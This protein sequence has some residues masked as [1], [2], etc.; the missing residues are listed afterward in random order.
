MGLNGP[1]LIRLSFKHGIWVGD[2][3]VGGTPP[4]KIVLASVV[5][6]SLSFSGNE[7]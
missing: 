6:G 7:S 2:F 3:F 5:V 4:Q 1:P